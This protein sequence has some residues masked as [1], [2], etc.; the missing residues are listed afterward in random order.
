VLGRDGQP[1]P[2]AVAAARRLDLRESVEDPVERLRRDARP[3]V[4]DPD[5]RHPIVR[6]E[7]DLDGRARGVDAGVVKKVA[8]DPVEAPRLG[9]DDDRRWR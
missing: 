4:G 3:A 2:A 9:L 8:E 7:P 5:H 6:R 1:E